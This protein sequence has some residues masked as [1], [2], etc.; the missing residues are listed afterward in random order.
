MDPRGLADVGRTAAAGIEQV[1]QARSARDRYQIAAANSKFSILKNAQDNAY[2]EDE[3]YETIEERWAENMNQGYNEILEGISNPEARNFFA[4]E[5]EPRIAAG[6]AKMNDVAFRKETDVQR[7]NVNSQ[8]NGLREVGLGNDEESSRVAVQN[9]T[10][11]I[12]AAV[13]TGY[14]SHEEGGKVLEAW[15]QD[16]ANGYIRM[17]APEDRVAALNSPMADHI[18][19]DDKAVLMRE[20]KDAVLNNKAVD[21]VDAL[22]EDFSARE[23]YENTD[24]I[25]DTK[26]RLKA[27]QRGEAV[28]AKREAREQEE[29]EEFHQDEYLPVLLGEKELDV[30][31]EEFRKLPTRLQDNL[32]SAQ[33]A[34]TAPRKKSDPWIQDTMIRMH[35]RRTTRRCGPTSRTT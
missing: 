18:P 33:Q 1:A 8:L 10:D 29:A 31:T 7:G 25:E 11:I 23:L 14:Y 4:L 9:A 12:E 35:Q 27:E 22:G 15:K 21:M 28:L 5:N 13:A 17:Q 24:K 20:A 3:D 16:T 32:I 30:N 6:R 2:D 34:K 26:L 19:S